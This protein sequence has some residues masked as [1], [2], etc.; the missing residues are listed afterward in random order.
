M[1]SRLRM[2]QSV[3]HPSAAARAHLTDRIQPLASAPKWAETLSDPAVT[4]YG[5]EDL[6]AR[7]RRA[8]RCR[9][10]LMSRA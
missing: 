1:G 4:S 10:W 3:Q 2:E 5:T 6:Q 9:E 7:L 8:L